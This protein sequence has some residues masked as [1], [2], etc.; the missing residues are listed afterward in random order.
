[1][2]FD[3]QHKYKEMFIVKDWIDLK[4]KDIHHEN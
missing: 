3:E 1:M 4:N 2:G